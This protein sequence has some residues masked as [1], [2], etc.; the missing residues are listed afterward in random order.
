MDAVDFIMA[1]ESGEATDEEIV[2]GM[3]AMIDSGVVWQLQ[4]CYG[5]MATR[6]IEAGLCHNREGE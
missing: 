2:T 1:Y 4:G 5:R 3:Q 6:L